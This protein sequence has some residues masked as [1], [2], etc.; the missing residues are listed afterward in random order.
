MLKSQ[1]LK[2]FISFHGQ[3]FQKRQTPSAELDA[4]AL[5]KSQST[6]NVGKPSHAQDLIGLFSTDINFE[7]TQDT[8]DPSPGVMGDVTVSEMTP[9]AESTRLDTSDNS[10][11]SKEVSDLLSDINNLNTDMKSPVAEDRP[12][13]LP[14]APPPDSQVSESWAWPASS[15]FSVADTAP[16]TLPTK[17]RPA[18]VQREKVASSLIS[19]PRPPSTTGIRARVSVITRITRS[20][21]S[22]FLK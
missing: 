2:L 15:S 5:K 17:Q 9:G 10:H 7:S 12:P 21:A 3:C 19:L 4:L 6:V 16:P 18:S 20:R 14:A 13:S 22:G 1:E 11:L 8:T